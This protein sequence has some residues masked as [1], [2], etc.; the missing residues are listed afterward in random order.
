M[1]SF[2]ILPLIAVFG[3]ARADAQT[4]SDQT[5]DTEQ[6][7]KVQSTD[8]GN[9]HPSWLFPME[10]VNRTLPESLRFGGEYRSRVEGRYGIGFTANKDLYLLSRFRF[11]ATIKPTQWLTVFSEL[12]DARVIFNNRFTPNTPTN[13]DSWDLRQA[14]VQLGSSKQGWIDLTVGRM[15]LLYGDERVIGPSDYT[16]TA[17]TFDAVRLN[18]HH[19]E[20]KVSLFASSV[21]VQRE[22]VIDHHFEGNNLYGIYGSLKNVVP[23]ATLEPYVLWRVAPS[24]PILSA[25]FFP[26]SLSQVT[27]GVRLAGFLPAAFDYN[28]EM[29]RQAGSI[30][31]RSIAAWAGYWSV[32]KTFRSVPTTPHLFFESNYAS[33][34][35]DRNGTTFHTYD[36]IFPSEHD[37]LAF[38]DLIGKRNIQQIRAGVVET[39]GKSRKLSLK[40]GYISFWAATTRD[41]LYTNSGTPFLPAAPLAR[42]RHVGQEIDLI[43]E[44]KFDEGIIAGFGYARLFAGSFLKAVS[45]G[46]DYNYPFLYLTY[47]F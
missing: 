2:A 25:S 21:V 23:Q 12:Q 35:K 15:V 26:G 40:Q 46:K 17:R 28:I 32:G 7:T 47:R 5:Q 14:Y 6:A 39:I 42:S 3:M 27:V 31:A 37:K 1:R 22:G 9:K 34:T 29:Q 36:E 8:T 16:N 19:G 13:Q 43:G 11:N 30:G 41:G 10:D 18:L 33:G 45:P 38:T 4:T 20:S 44:Y 24:N